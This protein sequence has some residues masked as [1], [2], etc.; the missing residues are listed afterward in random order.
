MAILPVVKYGNPILREKMKTVKD[1]SQISPLV[2][3]MFDTMYQEDGIGLAANQVGV[4][5]NLSVVD[6]SH[7]EESDTPLVFINGKILDKWGEAVME[8]GCLSLPGIRV[9]VP[10]AD[11]IRFNYHDLSGN[12]H[13]EEFHGLL[14]RVI[15]HEMDHLNGMMILDRVGSVLRQQFKKH[16]K[17]ITSIS[18]TEKPR[19]NSS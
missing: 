14:A 1:I 7:T 5:L 11:G 12:E 9:N 4:D 8:E 2:E 15:Q 16:L 19:E 17:D 3:N 13:I 6:I 18:N 10:R